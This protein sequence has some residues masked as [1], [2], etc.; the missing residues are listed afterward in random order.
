MRPQLPTLFT[1]QPTF[2]PVLRENIESSTKWSKNRQRWDENSPNAC[3]GNIYVG[4]YFC[5]EPDWGLS[6]CKQKPQRPFFNY[7][8]ALVCRL[9][10]FTLPLFFIPLVPCITMW[11]LEL[12]PAPRMLPVMIWTLYTMPAGQLEVRLTGITSRLQWFT[13]LDRSKG[14]AVARRNQIQNIYCAFLAAVELV[15]TKQAGL[16]PPR[17]RLAG[18]MQV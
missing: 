15:A 4:T 3:K 12:V 7:R 5:A 8:T 11:I 2:G 6:S 18:T 10:C 16:L 9:Y 14:G 1:G 13:A 17:L